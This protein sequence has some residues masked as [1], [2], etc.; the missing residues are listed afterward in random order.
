MATLFPRRRRRKATTATVL[1]RPISYISCPAFASIPPI[2]IPARS[3][4]V[5]GDTK[6]VLPVRLGEA[7]KLSPTGRRSAVSTLHIFDFDGT[8]IRTPMP[9]EGK[10]R[11]EAATGKKWKGG[12]WGRVGSLSPP[13]LESPV[14]SERIIRTVWTE[15]QNV[16]NHSNT[17]AAVVVT[18]RCKPL[19]P[20]VLRILGEATPDTFIEPIDEAAVFTHPGGRMS[21]LEWKKAL[22][23]SLVKAPPLANHPLKEV[24]IWEDR[25]EHAQA[26]AQEFAAFMKENAQVDVSVH[27]VPAD[28]P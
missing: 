6:I 15:F 7:L 9:D 12:W 14:A 22:I 24:H 3:S 8:L 19:R 13:V 21:T 11:Y 25:Q 28:M 10:R 17:A 4:A 5:M 1:S 26:F 23:H 16:Y 18:G 27:F 2:R 20:D